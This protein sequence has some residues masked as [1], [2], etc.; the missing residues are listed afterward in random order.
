M[1]T[2]T[3]ANG[4]VTS[5]CR[6]QTHEGKHKNAN[7]LLQEEMVSFVVVVAFRLLIS[8]IKTMCVCVRAN[9]YHCACVG[10]RLL[11]LWLPHI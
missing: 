2:N 5:I 9:V 7:K 1:S 6:H 3:K 8:I 4:D 11:P 10:V